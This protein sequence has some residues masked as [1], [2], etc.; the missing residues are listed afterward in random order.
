MKKTA[1]YMFTYCA[2]N[3]FIATSCP[4]LSFANQTLPKPPSPS[5]SIKISWSRWK[6]GRFLGSSAGNFTDR[7]VLLNVLGLPVVHYQMIRYQIQHNYYYNKTYTYEILMVHVFVCGSVWR[8]VGKCRQTR[9]IVKNSQP[10]V[11]SHI[12][13]RTDHVLLIGI[14]PGYRL[15]EMM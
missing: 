11:D 9:T 1:V 10:T 4:K 6:T 14:G 8:W 3:I 12:K 5:G 2:S 15:L 13:T 7:F